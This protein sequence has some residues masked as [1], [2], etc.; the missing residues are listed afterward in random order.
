MMDILEAI[1]IELPCGACGG[2]YE[3]ALKHVLLSQHMLHEGCPVPSHFM[4]EY[5]PVNYADLV[6]RGLLEEL[7]QAWRRLEEN[8]RATGIELLWRGVT[9]SL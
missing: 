8:A 6:D 2:R 4:S 7:Q 9:H 3:V 5:A 1:A